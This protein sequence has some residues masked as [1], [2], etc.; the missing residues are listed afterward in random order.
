MNKPIIEK[1]VVQTLLIKLYC[2]NCLSSIDKEEWVHNTELIK[3][4]EILLS[5]PPQYVYA[6]HCG[7]ETTSTESYPKIET[8]EIV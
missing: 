7:Y 5:N 4:K 8:E 2:P 3:Q 1:T 6:C